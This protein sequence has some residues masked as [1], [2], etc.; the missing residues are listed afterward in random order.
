[1]RKC[2][3]A[4]KSKA[5]FLTQTWCAKKN[6]HLSLRKDTPHI[7]GVRGIWEIFVPS[8]QFCCELKNYP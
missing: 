7:Y 6:S 3:L 1:M 4:R 2:I 5:L 8:P